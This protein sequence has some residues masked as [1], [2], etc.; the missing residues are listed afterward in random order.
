M[1]KILI[2][3]AKTMKGA[4]PFREPLGEPLFQ[5]EA[6]FLAG[7]A[8]A[9]T[10]EEA[11]RLWKCSD[12]LARENLARFQAWKESP[13]S[14]ALF[15]FDGI[16][17]RHIGAKTLGGKALSYLEGHLLLFSGLYGLLRPLDGIA[18]YRLDIGDRLAAGE[19]KNLYAFW[20]RKLYE[21]IEGHAVLNLASAEYSR[22]VTPYLAEG[23]RFIT[24]DFLTRKDGALRQQSTYAKMGRGEMVRFLAERE[25]PCPEEAKS[26]TALGFSFCSAA[27][28]EDHYVFCREGEAVERVSGKC[29][30]L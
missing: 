5:K 6:E 7:R 17:F 26:F 24:V 10:F 30:S 8:E 20:G 1:M 11:R 21:Q 12:A 29:Q 27:S 28:S 16:Q 2:S 3:P 22:A 9:L 15:S 19:A 14:A 4:A 18:P 25:A 13:R 23:T